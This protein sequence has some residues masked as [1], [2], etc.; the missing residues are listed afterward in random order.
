MKYRGDGVSSH[1]YEVKKLHFDG[2]AFDAVVFYLRAGEPVNIDLEAVLKKTKLW[3]VPTASKP[4]AVHH[5]VFEIAPQAEG[6]A[7]IHI[8][9]FTARL[10]ET[11]G[12]GSDD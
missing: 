7:E 4:E 5:L 10:G 3:T 2:K 6:I 1:D 9:K 8:S 12:G 11:D